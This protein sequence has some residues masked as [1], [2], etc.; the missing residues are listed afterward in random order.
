MNYVIAGYTIVLTLLFL[1]ALQLVWRRRRL[2]RTA[3][4]VAASNARIE[5]AGD[6]P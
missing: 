4:R 1:Y 5:R 3:T 6:G 2:T